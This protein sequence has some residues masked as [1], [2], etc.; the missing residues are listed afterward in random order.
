MALI[1]TI[2]DLADWA[3][4]R[5]YMKELLKGV[6]N[7]DPFFISK[8]DFDFEFK[9]SPWPGRAVL[10]G[11]K[12]QK[13][14]MALKKAGIQFRTGTCRLVGKKLLVT[15]LSG[16]LL[17][18][19]NKTLAKLSVGVQLGMDGG[20]DEVAA[21]PAAADPAEATAKKTKAKLF[22][23]LKKVLTAKPAN[24]AEFVKLYNEAE[25]LEKA[26]DF[27]R[28]L[29][30][31]RTLDTLVKNAEDGKGGA[32]E[33]DGDAGE[34]A[35]AKKLKAKLFP[36][37]KVALASHSANRTT[38]AALAKSAV[39]SEKAGDWSA[40]LTAFGNLEKELARSDSIEEPVVDAPADT[41]DEDE[42]RKR[43]AGV[44]R[45][46][47]AALSNNIGDR[48]E[49]SGLVKRADASEKKGDFETVLELYDAIEMHLED[50]ADSAG[51]ETDV[52]DTQA[53]ETTAKRA[54]SGLYKR[55]KAALTENPEARESIARLVKEA[56]AHEKAGRFDEL[57]ESYE[58]VEEVL[59]SLSDDGE[60]DADDDLDFGALRQWGEYRMYLR[61]R[62]RK[63]PK[64]P[65]QTEPVFV[66]RKKI[67]FDLEGK[68]WRGN[69]VLAGAKARKM[70][71]AMKREGVRFLEGECYV[72]GKT[73]M[74]SGL[75]GTALKAGIKTLKMARLGFKMR[76]AGA[77]AGATAEES[78]RSTFDARYAAIQR[79]LQAALSDQR[80]D[81]SA[82]RATD[83]YA[84]DQ[85]SAENW[86][87]AMS[88][89]DRLERLLGDAET[90]VAGEGTTTP[91]LVGYRKSLVS[92]AQTKSSVRGQLSSLK[93]QVAGIPGEADLAD[94]LESTLE[95]LFEQIADSVDAAINAS[96]DEREPVT[97]AVRQ[98]LDSAFQLVTTSPILAHV[99]SS[100]FGISIQGPLKNALSD[101][102]AKIPAA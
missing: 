97:L 92:F 53:A 59:D 87:S 57:L 52:A 5:I 98:E 60:D 61:R 27:S 71:K 32:P 70:V 77:E 67:E 62:L 47:K 48:S 19:G 40:V 34:A 41:G 37:I 80:G 94:A 68:P 38:I 44:Y 58:E 10:F 31:Y 65:D 6:A 8:E 96:Q 12:G 55:V 1:K 26:R 93:K 50:A 101:I 15:D 63:L 30:V 82:M 36:R 95:K 84:T 74:V 90:A 20:D 45:A 7:G 85:A 28:L 25:K 9:G 91:G 23:R 72:Q 18:A 17:K 4:Y 21:A 11:A 69:V 16:G 22:P 42:A 13:S 2:D 3:G 88:S 24:R 81:V 66:G 75:A 76:M 86:P 33:D 51:G 64:T 89:L 39:A 43:K 54:K 14:M 78:L 56:D 73:L 100:P 29:R 46:V 49:I 102:R 35:R 83:S 79:R 99:E